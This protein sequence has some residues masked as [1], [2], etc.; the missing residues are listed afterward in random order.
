MLTLE[1]RYIWFHEVSGNLR[2]LAEI[3]I[4]VPAEIQIVLGRKYDSNSF[5]AQALLEAEPDQLASCPAAHCTYEREDPSEVPYA[6]VHCPW[7]CLAMRLLFVA[8]F[9][10]SAL[11][12][13]H[14]VRHHLVRRDKCRNDTYVGPA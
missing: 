3:P 10:A 4:Y 5:S 7:S 11:E 14:T 2:E 6:S 13:V 12:H 9:F 8:L 1:H